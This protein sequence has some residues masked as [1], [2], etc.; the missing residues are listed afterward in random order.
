MFSREA[1]ATYLNFL[2]AKRDLLDYL[3]ASCLVR[4]WVAVVRGLEDSLVFGT[5][6]RV[7]G[8]CIGG[9]S[10]LVPC[11]LPLLTRQWLVINM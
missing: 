1:F 6:K 7:N 8:L 3:K 11:P 4:L 5:G 2:L 10:R 9:M